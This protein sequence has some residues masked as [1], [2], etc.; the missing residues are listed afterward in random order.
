MKF[1]PGNAAAK[2]RKAPQPVPIS[3]L[4]KRIERMQR[5]IQRQLDESN[6]LPT[7][8]EHAQ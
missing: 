4:L 8:Q 6:E 2:G 5:Q 3:T 1:K 7:T